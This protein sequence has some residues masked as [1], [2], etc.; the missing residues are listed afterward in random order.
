M[1]RSMF[2]SLRFRARGT[3]RPDARVT[4]RPRGAGRP[5]SARGASDRGDDHQRLRARPAD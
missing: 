1:D 5:R 2:A 3:R 4:R